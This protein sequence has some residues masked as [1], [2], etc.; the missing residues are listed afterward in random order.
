MHTHFT[1][2]LQDCKRPGVLEAPSPSAPIAYSILPL[3]PWSSRG[4]CGTRSEDLPYSG[5]L[6][7]AALLNS[8]AIPLRTCLR[9]LARWARRG[10]LPLRRHSK[11]SISRVLLALWSPRGVSG[12]GLV[13]SSLFV[14]LTPTLSILPLWTELQPLAGYP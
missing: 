6:S 7:S 12:A 11:Q 10:Q 8:Q 14:C 4:Y 1:V 5:W 13:T 3:W 2:P 9:L